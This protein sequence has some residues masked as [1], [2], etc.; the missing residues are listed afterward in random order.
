MSIFDYIPTLPEGSFDIGD[1]IEFEISQSVVNIAQEVSDICTEF[2][3]LGTELDILKKMENQNLSFE[4]F[5]GSNIGVRISTGKGLIG[6]VLGGTKDPVTGS[7]GVNIQVEPKITFGEL[8]IRKMKELISRVWMSIKNFFI[9]IFH[10]FQSKIAQTDKLLSDTNFS[11]I[12]AYYSNNQN[13]NVKLTQYSV[14]NPIDE[15][16]KDSEILKTSIPKLR[17][18]II[19]V[20]SSVENPVSDFRYK[21]SQNITDNN[22]EEVSNIIEEIYRGILPHNLNSDIAN[23]MNISR[24]IRHKYFG[25]S[26]KKVSQEIKSVVDNPAI[27]EYIISNDAFKSFRELYKENE[28]TINE[29]TKEVDR[30]K[31]SL[32]DIYVN[33]T[34]YSDLQRKMVIYRKLLTTMLFTVI[35]YWELYFTIRSDVMAC[36]RAIVNESDNI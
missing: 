6:S 31:K 3:E 20:I 19:S 14:S 29:A 35:I 1:D 17:N 32:Q 33:S 30:F 27:Y 10:F 5:S 24:I 36:A 21:R 8:F 25:D 7:K 11:K 26:K 12:Q 23:E 34:Y 2:N 9:S 22:I 28:K 13:T 4:D 15:Y 18:A 16:M